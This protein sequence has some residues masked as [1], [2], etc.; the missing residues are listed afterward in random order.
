MASVARALCVAPETVRRWGAGATRTTAT[1]LVPVEVISD[2]PTV[3]VPPRVVTVV[4]PGGYRVEGLTVVD[5]AMLLRVL[6]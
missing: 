5:A 6:R 3:A 4:A 1:A 2:E